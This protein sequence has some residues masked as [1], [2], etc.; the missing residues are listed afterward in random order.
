MAPLY[1]LHINKITPK[2]EFYAKL[3]SMFCNFNQQ[4]IWRALSRRQKEEDSWAHGF[5]DV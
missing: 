3:E 2:A 1:A 4:E 5:W